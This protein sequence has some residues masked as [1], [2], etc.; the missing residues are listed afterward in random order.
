VWLVDHWLLLPAGTTIRTST[1][2]M[3]ASPQTAPVGYRRLYFPAEGA[4][5]LSIPTTREASA[6]PVLT[7]NLQTAGWVFV[8]WTSEV[9][10][11]GTV[12]VR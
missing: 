6:V 8:P 7:G 5:K 2:G 12:T 4:V 3:N 10:T 11:D 9:W 1:P